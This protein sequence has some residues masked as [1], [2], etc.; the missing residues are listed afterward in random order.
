MVVWVATLLV[1]GNRKALVVGGIWQVAEADSSAE[2]VVVSLVAGVSVGRAL[3]WAGRPLVA[4]L[5]VA[6]LMG[7][8]LASV[9]AEV[10]GAL[11]PVPVLAAPGP[12]LDLAPPELVAAAPLVAAVARH[13]LE[14]AAVLGCP[15]PLAV[16]ADHQ[17]VQLVEFVAGKLFVLVV[18]VVLLNCK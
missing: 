4:A 18:V 7:V 2:M 1:V 15:A 17:Q 9:V 12:A 16:V 6:A 3:V 11:V 14:S 13:P 8:E 10:G 5:Q